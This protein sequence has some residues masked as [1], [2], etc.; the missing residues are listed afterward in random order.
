MKNSLTTIR[1]R[2]GETDQMGV[3]HHGNYA[4]YFEM[5]RID[6]LSQF[7]ISYGKM[8]EEGIMMPV[9]E[10]KIK[11]RRPARFDDLL[12]VEASLRE[13]PDVRI[14][15]DYKIMDEEK[16]LL[17]TAYTELV[18]LDSKT[19]RPISCPEYILKKIKA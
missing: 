8:E 2:Y 10:M 18:F 14:K 1:V 13:I 15:F 9:R 7:G 5:A 17:T 11:F 3:V 4:Q 19:R 6:W 12:T 16:N